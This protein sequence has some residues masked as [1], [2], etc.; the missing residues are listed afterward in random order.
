M[1]FFND[2]SEASC[3]RLSATRNLARLLNFMDNC[4]GVT[5]AACP[6]WDVIEDTKA[7]YI[8]RDMCGLPNKDYADTSSL[9]SICFGCI[10]MSLSQT[11]FWCRVG[12]DGPNLGYLYP[13]YFISVYTPNTIYRPRPYIV[14]DVKDE[15]LRLTMPKKKGKWTRNIIMREP[16]FL[17]QRVKGTFL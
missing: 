7:L 2:N 1:I 10:H 16:M 17:G 8:I 6:R 14:M 15:V 9:A 11:T 12:R 4:I 5:T 3:P 13:G